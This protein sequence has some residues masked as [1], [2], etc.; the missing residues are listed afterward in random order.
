M[1]S[2]HR[3]VFAGDHSIGVKIDAGDN[4]LVKSVTNK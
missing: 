2:A 1:D 3:V 4:G